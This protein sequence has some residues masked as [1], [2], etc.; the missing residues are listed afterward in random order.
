LRAVVLVVLCALP[1]TAPFA[2][3][4]WANLAGETSV[5][6]SARQTR[7]SVMTSAPPS[8]PPAFHA[9]SARDPWAIQRARR[10]ASRHDVATGE[11]ERPTDE[12][13]HSRP[14]TEG[15]PRDQLRDDEEKRDVRSEQA[16]E[17]PGESIHRVTVRR[18]H[19]SASQ[20]ERHALARRCAVHS[21]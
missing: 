7:S 15:N 13:R 20:Y 4:D 5:H 17:V 1:F 16:A 10:L 21:R 18:Q 11:D 14:L 2:A 6:A 3:W 19:E 8:S 12:Q 9:C